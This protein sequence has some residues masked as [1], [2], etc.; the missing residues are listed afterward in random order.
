MQEFHA[1][2]KVCENQHMQQFITIYIMT[3]WGFVAI[4]WNIFEE[5]ENI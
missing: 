4:A 5:K 1:Y 3:F 2:A